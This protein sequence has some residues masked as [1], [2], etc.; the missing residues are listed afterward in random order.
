M[1]LQVQLLHLCLT[2]VLQV[3][4]MVVDMVVGLA[5]VEKEE[6]VQ[7][8]HLFKRYGKQPL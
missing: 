8:A 6:E 5:G 4:H 7:V 1:Q 2:Q 3:V